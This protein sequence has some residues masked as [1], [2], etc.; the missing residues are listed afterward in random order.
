[1]AVLRGELEVVRRVRMPEDDSV[2]TS[3][4][5]ELA[6]ALETQAIGVQA[7]KGFEMV[8]GARHPH[9][10]SGHVLCHWRK[11]LVLLVDYPR[12]PG[13]G[14]AR[15]AC[16]A[17]HRR[18]STTMTA[19]LA[20]TLITALAIA[21]T[22]RG[23]IAQEGGIAVG[24]DA[25]SARVL[26]LDGKAI[27]LADFYDGKPVVLE[28]WAT[29]CPLCKKMEPAM[30]A[31]RQRHGDRVTFV[32]VGVTANQTADRQREYAAK[33]HLTGTFVFDADGAAIKAFSVPH[34]SYIVVI[35]ASRHVVYTGVGGD[36]DIEAALKKA[37][38]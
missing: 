28:F 31:A 19:G 10:D 36:Q 15:Q 9:D 22:S 37:S 26:T 27:D 32:S 8:R 16:T 7:R 4:I 29:W 11:L 17:S 38:L 18:G 3:M 6:E 21:V 25:P 24:K 14:G 23:A 2:E 20:R 1:V 12:V 30:E 33:Q 13:F 34:T 35:D 5:H